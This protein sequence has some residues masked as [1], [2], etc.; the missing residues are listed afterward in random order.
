M[1]RSVPQHRPNAQSCRRAARRFFSCR[2]RLMKCSKCGRELA[3]QARFCG[4]CGQ[5]VIVEAEKQPVPVPASSLLPPTTQAVVAPDS[6]AAQKLCS[7]LQDLAAMLPLR[8]PSSNHTGSRGCGP[9][10]STGQAHHGSSWRKRSRQDDPDQPH[11]GTRHLA[12]RHEEL[13]VPGGVASGAFVASLFRL[14]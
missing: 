6:A 8:N 1:D 5:E 2:S 9:G 12:D 13:A 4:S 7:E 3:R 10:S 14:P 11:A